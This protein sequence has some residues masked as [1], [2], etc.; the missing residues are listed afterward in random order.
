MNRPAGRK[1]ALA[2]ALGVLVVAAVVAVTVRSGASHPARPAEA[3]SGL[4]T[5]V[6]PT[7][8]AKRAAGSAAPLT[9]RLSHVPPGAQEVALEIDV[10]AGRNPVI[11]AVGPGGGRALPFQAAVA[12]RTAGSLYAI[13]GLGARP[14]EVV[15]TGAVPAALTVAVA[16]WYGSRGTGFTPTPPDPVPV[17]GG[18]GRAGPAHR[19]DLAGVVPAGAPAVAL[20]LDDTGSGGGPVEVYAGSTP[21][22]APQIGGPGSAFVTVGLGRGTTLHLTGAGAG[23]VTVRLVGYWQPPGGAD[24][25]PLGDRFVPAPGSGRIVG[26]GT[27][28]LAGLVGLSPTAVVVDGPPAG[29]QTVG[30]AGWPAG[31]AAPAATSEPVLLGPDQTLAVTGGPV[32]IDGW[33]QPVATPPGD[34][35]GGSWARSVPA[36][37]AGSPRDVAAWAAQVGAQ[38]DGAPDVNFPGVR[39]TP[40]Y[41]ASPGTPTVEVTL[42]PAC[43]AAG[44]TAFAGQT[45]PAPIPS[46]ASVAPP[47]SVNTDTP[48]VVWQPATS[49]DWEY[50]QAEPAGR[51]WTACDGGRL[52]DIASGPGTWTGGDGLSATGI[53]Y[54][55]TLLTEADVASGSIRHVLAFTVESG[56]CDGHVAPA[57]RNDPD[58]ATPGQPPE[59]TVMYLPAAT[60][61]PA[62][63]SPLAQMVF[64]A[65]QHYG[66]VLIDQS[67]GY[68]NLQ[69]ESSCDYGPERCGPGLAAAGPVTDPIAVAS[70]TTGLAGIPWADLLSLPAGSY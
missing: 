56:R 48:L 42:G 16:G 63:L 10:A 50:W 12:A 22:A 68:V 47:H 21:P 44:D 15:T 60:P 9:I 5:A 66:L 65:L 52:S 3:A 4:F 17:L 67:G 38:A 2:A 64:V 62:G 27:V 7:L 61:M 31:A 11:V 36:D 34:L 32:V 6:D 53:S 41:M 59:G 29:G 35:F 13:V 33:Y 8:V 24:H 54:L 70:G 20:S 55:A 14:S 43:G 49:S 23:D 26:P 37:P 58:C 39:G 45:G 40:V 69:G 18:A 30:P 25:V 57:T 1:A 46:G 19:L 51:D 28:S